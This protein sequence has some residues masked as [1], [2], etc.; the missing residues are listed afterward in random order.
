MSQIS[1]NSRL[2]QDSHSAVIRGKGVSSI[3]DSNTNGMTCELY[4]ISLAQP[5][6]NFT[7]QERGPADTSHYSPQGKPHTFPDTSL[8][9]TYFQIAYGCL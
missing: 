4:P 8:R 5:I 2:G 3:I 1:E 9:G 6:P 7:V